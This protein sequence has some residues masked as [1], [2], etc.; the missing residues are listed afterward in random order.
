MVALFY[1]YET[2]TVMCVSWWPFGVWRMPM[3]VTTS[4]SQAKESTYE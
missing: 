1:S 2:A 4:S 3:R